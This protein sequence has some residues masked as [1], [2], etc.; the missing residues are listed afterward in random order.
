MLPPALTLQDACQ[1]GPDRSRRSIAPP[2]AFLPLIRATD[3]DEREALYYDI[4]DLLAEE[5]PVLPLTQSSLLA[6]AQP[7]VDGVVLDAGNL[8]RYWLIFKEFF[9]GAPAPAPAPAPEPQRSWH[10]DPP[11]KEKGL[12]L[13]V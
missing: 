12:L 5:L 2:E 7:G 9:G 3:A 6:V 13:Q 8:L 11:A 1:P 4:Q 10:G